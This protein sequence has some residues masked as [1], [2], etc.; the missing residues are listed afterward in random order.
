MKNTFL[1]LFTL[2]FSYSFAQTN[3]KYV[4]IDFNSICCGPP[5][6]QIILDYLGNFQKQNKLGDFEMWKETGLGREGEYALFIG[7]DQLN[8]TNK[9]KFI[10]GLEK[11]AAHFEAKRNKNQDGIIQLQKNL[12]KKKEL[13]IK[14]QKPTNQRSELIPYQF[15]T[16][17]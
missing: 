12:I 13:A 16:I 1:L 2:L 8:C 7:L 17:Q 4:R 5:S 11:V 3:K 15:N 14:Q 9:K 6:D 10:S